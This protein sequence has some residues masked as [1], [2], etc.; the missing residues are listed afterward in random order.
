MTVLGNVALFAGLFSAVLS[1]IVYGRSAVSQKR[2]PLPG[3]LL[4]F[5]CSVFVLAA[6]LVLLDR[7]LA[8]DYSV[9]YVY[10]YSDSA[11][12]LHYLIS[13]FYAGQE[14]SFLF[15][16]L[17]SSVIALFLHRSMKGRGVEAPVMAVFMAVEAFLILLVVVRSPFR[18]VWDVFPG[19]PPSP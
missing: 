14:G 10:S 12:P 2:S 15:W 6:S 17:C 18:S 9:S 7:I 11:L 1:A 13:S 19:A 5:A 3:R 16:A 4:L 8:H